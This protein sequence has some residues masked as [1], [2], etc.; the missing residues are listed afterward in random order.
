[1]LLRDGKLHL[2][3]GRG[4]L[5]PL[6]ADRFARSAGGQVVFVAKPGARE[7][8]LVLSAGGSTAPTIFRQLSPVTGLDLSRYAGQYYSEELDT[9]YTLRVRDGRLMLIRK[10]EAPEAMTPASPGVFLLQSGVTV[11]FDGADARASG[12]RVH[13]G[14]VRNLE[15]GRVGGNQGMAFERTP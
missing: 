6:A 2:A 13:A 14:R 4:E 10:G 3:P 9:T 5:T 15:F 7:M 11:E 8:Q 12:F 1:V